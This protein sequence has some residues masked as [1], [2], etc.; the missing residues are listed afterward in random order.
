MHAFLILILLLQETQNICRFY[1]YK[2]VVK[3]KLKMHLLYLPLL[4]EE[5]EIVLGF[6][7]ARL[8]GW[9]MGVR[10]YGWGLILVLG[11]M[12]IRLVRLHFHFK[13]SSAFFGISLVNSLKLRHTCY[14]N[15]L[16]FPKLVANTYCHIHPY[17]QENNSFLFSSQVF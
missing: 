13:V 15:R 4:K 11:S 17:Q 3:T 2:S 8:W 5:V 16:T 6:G 10:M 1:P 7:L 14:P 9:G 12:W